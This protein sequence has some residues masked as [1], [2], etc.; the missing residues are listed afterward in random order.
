MLNGKEVATTDAKGVYVIDDMQAGTHK[1]SVT[2]S[3]V[4]FDDKT[5]T[6]SHN[7]PNLPLITPSR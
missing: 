3:N 6:I 2:A 4:Y 1:I 5:V 7:E